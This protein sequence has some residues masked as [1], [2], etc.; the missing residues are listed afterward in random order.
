MLHPW[1]CFLYWF[2]IISTSI[3]YMYIYFLKNKIYILG[4]K[5]LYS[6]SSFQ[7]FLPLQKR[8]HLK[9][10]QDVTGW[11]RDRLCGV[12]AIVFVSVLFLSQLV[13]CSPSL[14]DNPSS[15]PSRSYGR[16]TNRS[17]ALPYASVRFVCC[18][19]FVFSFTVFL[20]NV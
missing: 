1:W 17:T 10:H 2:Y 15:K 19:L 18:L 8:K 11:A 12:T 3:Y 5:S 20:M 7:I 16:Q 6:V 13:G 9:A 4:K 14:A